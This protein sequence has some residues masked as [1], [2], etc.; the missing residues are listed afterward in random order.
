MSHED[1]LLQE[2]RKTE[3]SGH[4]GFFVFFEQCVSLG[5]FQQHDRKQV[6]MRD[7]F[8]RIKSLI[9]DVPAFLPNKTLCCPCSTNHTNECYENMVCSLCFSCKRSPPHERAQINQYVFR[10]LDD[11]RRFS[12]DKIFNY[13][14]PS[15]LPNNKL[16]FPYSTNHTNAS[17]ENIISLSFSWKSFSPKT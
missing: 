2:N 4:D 5:V 11:E 3:K 15:F 7:D 9:I 17:C 8:P 6:L 13:W 16:C 12:Q 1:L 10:M 14:F